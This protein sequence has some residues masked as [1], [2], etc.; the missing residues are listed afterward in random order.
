MQ[1]ALDVATFGEAMLLLVAQQPGPL[2]Q[3][4]T[5]SKRTAGAEEELRRASGGQ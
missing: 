4:Q 1:H 5:F 2:E 3:V